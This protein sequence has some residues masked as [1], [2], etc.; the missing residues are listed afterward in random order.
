[1]K[2][3]IHGGPN[4]G[5]AAG[6]ACGGLVVNDHDRFERM[7]LVRVEPLFHFRWLSARAPVAGDIFDLDPES[8]RHLPPQ[9]G[10]MSGLEHQYT[11]PRRKRVHDGGFPGSRPR[12]GIH[13][14]R[15]SG[16]KNRA[17]TLENL[18]SQSGEFGTTMI[19]DRTIH[20]AQDPVG[21]VGGPGNL[22]KM[23][24]AVF[25]FMFLAGL[26]SFRLPWRPPSSFLSPS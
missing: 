18:P 2:G 11:I 24:A 19:D 8:F 22:K 5:Y 21:H 15:R 7:L 13:Q 12:S 25:Q 6:Y 26:T 4:L 14:H 9:L 16:L 10:K 1:M 20:G 23:V 3:S 17:Q